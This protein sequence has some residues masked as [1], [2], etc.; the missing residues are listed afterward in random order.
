MTYGNY[1]AGQSRPVSNPV[2]NNGVRKA[3]AGKT[4]FNFDFG[5]NNT[6]GAKAP[7]EITRTTVTPETR[8][9]EQTTVTSTAMANIYKSDIADAK[10]DL[11]FGKL[12]F[13]LAPEHIESYKANFAVTSSRLAFAEQMGNALFKENILA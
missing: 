1:D 2:S 9:A 11:E 3:E 12:L 5:F 13:E 8:I 10:Y 6:E 7:W 4:E